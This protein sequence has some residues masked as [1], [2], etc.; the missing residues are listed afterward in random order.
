[1]YLYSVQCDDSVSVEEYCLILSYLFPSGMKVAFCQL[2]GN[3]NRLSSVTLVVQVV[4]RLCRAQ[5]QVPTPLQEN[6]FHSETLRQ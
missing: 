1:M 2:E 5:L 4:P 6:V 3:K